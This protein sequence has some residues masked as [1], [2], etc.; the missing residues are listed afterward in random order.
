MRRSASMLFSLRRGDHEGGT[1]F[2]SGVRERNCSTINRQLAS[3]Q[4]PPMGKTKCYGALSASICDSKAS[5]RQVDLSSQ[6][7]H[8]CVWTRGVTHIQTKIDSS[9]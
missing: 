4:L 1:E 2:P 3:A 8:G 6:P 7:S 5:R 9:R